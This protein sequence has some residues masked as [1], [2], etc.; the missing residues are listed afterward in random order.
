[1]SCH[2]IIISFSVC[3]PYAKI[4]NPALFLRVYVSPHVSGDK[5]NGRNRKLEIKLNYRKMDKENLTAV[6]RD[7]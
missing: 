7:Y 5:C 6:W 1:M 4:L 2:I 3:K